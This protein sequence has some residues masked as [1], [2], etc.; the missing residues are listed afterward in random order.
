MVSCTHGV[1][2]CFFEVVE[3]YSAPLNVCVLVCM[4]HFQE[5]DNSVDIDEDQG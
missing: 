4:R 1:Y 5:W 2:M 3:I